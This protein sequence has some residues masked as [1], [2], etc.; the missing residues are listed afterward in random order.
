MDILH[1]TL[2]ARTV[3][4]EPHDLQPVGMIA[5]MLLF[6]L[7]V[8]CEAVSTPRR[9]TARRAADVPLQCP[10]GKQPNEENTG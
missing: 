7:A 1:E 3:G 2:R 4:E 6:S 8:R 9:L 5:K 10:A